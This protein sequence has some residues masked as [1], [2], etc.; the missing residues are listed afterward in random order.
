M[1]AARLADLGGHKV[2]LMEK[3]NELGG[4]VDGVSKLPRLYTRDLRKYR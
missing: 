2:T 3:R 4:M 1:E